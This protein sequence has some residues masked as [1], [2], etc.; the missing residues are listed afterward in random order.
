MNNTANVLLRHTAAAAIV[1]SSIGSLS[2]QTVS[3]GSNETIE[4]ASG[5]IAI[6]QPSGFTPAEQASIMQRVNAK[7]QAAGINLTATTGPTGPCRIIISDS[8]APPVIGVQGN[9]TDVGDGT[10]GPAIIFTAEHPD[11]PN[12]QHVDDIA[13][14]IK[15]LIASK[16]GA[17]ANYQTNVNAMTQ[18][19]GA[20]RF[21]D[22]PYGGNSASQMQFNAGIM[23]AMA[24]KAPRPTDIR[25]RV[26]TTPGRRLQSLDVELT[27]S[28]GLQTGSRFGHLRADGTFVTYGQQGFLPVAPASFF[29]DGS[30]VDFAIRLSNGNVYS[31]SNGK[32][33][34][35]LLHVNA[36]N[37]DVFD[38]FDVQFDVNG[39]GVP[40]ATV[41]VQV[42]G[43]GAGGFYTRYYPGTDEDLVL[44]GSVNVNAAYLTGQ[45]AQT[46]QGGDIFYPRVRSSE[47]QFAGAPSLLVAEAFVASS[48]VVA[49]ALPGVQVSTGYIVLQ[50]GLVG[51]AGMLGSL[52]IPAG[53]AGYHLLL[54]GFA[55]SSFAGNGLYG[56]TDAMTLTFL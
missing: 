50:A 30:G 33:R 54:Q 25:Y 55:I 1:L 27:Y 31:L 56:A 45:R 52:P 28:P 37:P 13:N 22:L 36:S 18:I 49:M 10:G 38:R 29:F 11:V 8:Q 19:Q 5:W 14:S 43:N 40:D 4:L 51:P 17:G 12:Y 32:G 26:D 16:H 3:F 41:H 39:D 6:A 48:P 53:W 44:S 20:A 2:A 46:A 21:T 42:A 23:N 7:L 47:G 15:A 9:E 24:E 35:Q 34:T